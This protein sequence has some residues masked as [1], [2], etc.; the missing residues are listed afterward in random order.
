LGQGKKPG[1]W[2]TILQGRYTGR[3]GRIR[4]FFQEEK[5]GVPMEG[6]LTGYVL[7]IKDVGKRAFWRHELKLNPRR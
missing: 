6:G 4:D 5:D 7:G 1:R 3:S 2:A